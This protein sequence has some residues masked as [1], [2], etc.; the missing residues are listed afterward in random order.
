[1]TIRS[2]PSKVALSKGPVIMAPGIDHRENSN[3]RWS[4]SQHQVHL[5]P[6]CDLMMAPC[7]ISLLCPIQI[8]HEIVLLPISIFLEFRSM[9]I[10]AH[11]HINPK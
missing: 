4:C 5:L 10:I 8:L 9:D 3:G 1:M 11:S 6:H 7:L 2:S